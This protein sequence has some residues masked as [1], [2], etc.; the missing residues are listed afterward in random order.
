MAK[1]VV[2]DIAVLGNEGASFTDPF[3]FEITFECT[4]ALQH[5]AEPK[6][7]R[8]RLLEGSVGCGSSARAHRCGVVAPFSTGPWLTVLPNHPPSVAL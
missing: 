8:V 3:K 5:G 7:R 4:D 6:P 1:V 2:Q